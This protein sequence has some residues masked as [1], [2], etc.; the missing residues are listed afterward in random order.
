MKK[1]TMLHRC[2]LCSYTTKYPSYLKRHGFAHTSAKAISCE[3][4]GAK[5][6]EECA[7]RLHVKETHASRAHICEM[8]GLEFTHRR[9]LERHLL[10]HSDEKP[11]AC[12]KCGYACKRKQDLH[13]H[14]RAMHSGKPRR[15]Q[16]EEILA[17]FFTSLHVTF[18]REYTLKIATFGGR[19][20]ARVDFYIPMPWGALLF[21]CDEMQHSCYNVLHECKRM[22]SIRD[23]YVRRFPDCL[24]HIVR[25]NSH[26]YKQ[27]GLVRKPTHEERT[28]TIKECLAYV[29]TVAFVITYVYYRA[30]HGCA[31]IATHPEYTLQ[32]Y[33]RVIA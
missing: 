2:P 12:A 1:K 5:F 10:C 30:Q 26:A 16:H 8:C 29:P 20:S 33:V 9:A 15:K 4:C 27:D 11:I 28:A 21:E 18:T 3:L 6:K 22:E 17:G 19:K 7:Y 32:Q 14:T 25:Y 23:F 24:L 13:R 31:V